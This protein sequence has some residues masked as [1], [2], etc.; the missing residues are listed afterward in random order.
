MS[1]PFTQLWGRILVSHSVVCLQVDGVAR[2]QVS[3]TMYHL[4]NMQDI[5]GVIGYKA[6]CSQKGQVTLVRSS[7]L[8][9]LRDSL[10]NTPWNVTRIDPAVIEA[11]YQAV[12]L[13]I[14]GFRSGHRG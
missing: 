2:V 11:L 12:R 8:V 7:T 14:C 10:S 9:A 5:R 6:H 3:K 13:Q 1:F 4:T